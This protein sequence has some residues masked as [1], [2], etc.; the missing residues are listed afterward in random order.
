MVAKGGS[1][2]FGFRLPYG[3]EGAKAPGTYA[4]Q[5]VIANHPRIVSLHIP[6]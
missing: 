4:W 5:G 3:S 1:T 2:T 6:A